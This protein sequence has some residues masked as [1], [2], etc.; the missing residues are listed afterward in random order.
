MIHTTR[1]GVARLYYPHTLKGNYCAGNPARKISNRRAPVRSGLILD[2]AAFEKAFDK[3]R[4]QCE[5]DILR[6]IANDFCS[7]KRG[8]FLK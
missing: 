6:Q 2:A 8:Q 5:V 7:P 4:L 1:L 3:R